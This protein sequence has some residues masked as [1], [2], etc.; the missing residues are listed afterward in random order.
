MH[1]YCANYYGSVNCHNKVSQFG[2]RCRLCTVMNEGRSARLDTMNAAPMS[3]PHSDSSRSA[4]SRE[5][6]RGRGRERK[7]RGHVRQQS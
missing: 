3:Y 5:D 2:D 1:C 6:P 4:S 7:S